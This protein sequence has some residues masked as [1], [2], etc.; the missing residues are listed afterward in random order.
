MNNLSHCWNETVWV[1]LAS[2][3]GERKEML[4]KDNRRNLSI[5]MS[6]YLWKIR[7]VVGGFF[8][9][10]VF[11]FLFKLSH[12]FS[13][14]NCTAQL[15][16]AGMVWLPWCMNDRSCHLQRLNDTSVF[17]GGLEDT[18]MTGSL[19]PIVGR[20][21][22]A[23]GWEFTTYFLQCSLSFLSLPGVLTMPLFVDL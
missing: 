11:L 17:T 21:Y 7:S 2:R 19:Q 8:F 14:T 9:L 5:I 3:R 22:D 6:Q 13:T 23:R 12:G 16:Q 1:R 15:A 10:I 18:K 4:S 20:Y